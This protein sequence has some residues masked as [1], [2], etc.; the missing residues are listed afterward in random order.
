VSIIKDFNTVLYVDGNQSVAQ[1]TSIRHLWSLLRLS[2]AREGSDSLCQ[3]MDGPDKLSS[4][5]TPCVSFSFGKT[6]T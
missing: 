1:L 2:A 6:H 4:L 3:D 5:L